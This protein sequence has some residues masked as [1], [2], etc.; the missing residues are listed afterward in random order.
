MLCILPCRSTRPI[1]MSGCTSYAAEGMAGAE[2]ADVVMADGAQ[3]T[4]DFGTGA[5]VADLHSGAT[6][7]TDLD[8]GIVR[9]ADRM[10]ERTTTLILTME[11]TRTTGIRNKP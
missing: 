1:L 6:A 8:G 7:P 2:A 9:I 11:R 4:L 10:G 3:D 5:T